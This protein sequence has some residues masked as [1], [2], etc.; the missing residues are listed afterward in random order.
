[1]Q[2]P[3]GESAHKMLEVNDL[4]VSY[5]GAVEALRGISLSVPENAVVAV[6]GSNG[7]GKSTLLRAVSSVLR[8]YRG[9]IDGGSITFKGTSLRGLDPAA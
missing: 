9:R 2:V 7:A 5:G 6:L 4:R 1:M 8:G 3:G